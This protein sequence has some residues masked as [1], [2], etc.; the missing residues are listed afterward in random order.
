[1]VTWVIAVPINDL[2]DIIF[3]KVYKFDLNKIVIQQIT[4]SPQHIKLSANDINKYYKLPN[5]Y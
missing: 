1:M 2:S 3:R 5:K 4:F